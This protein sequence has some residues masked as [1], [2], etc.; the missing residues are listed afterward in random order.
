VPVL[1]IDTSSLVSVAVVDDDTVVARGVET[2]PRVH[3]ERLSMVIRDAM[4]DSGLKGTDLE[5]IAVGTGPAP[6]TGLRIGL[7]T[8]RVLSLAWGI[9]AWG[10]CS[11]DAIGAEHGGEVTVVTDARRREVYW[12]TYEAGERVSGP[13]VTTPTEVAASGERVGRGTLLYAEAFSAMGDTQWGE[14]GSDRESPEVPFLDPDPA[15][16]ARV[17]A[18]RIAGG[19]T[20]LPTTPLYL[21]RPDTHGIAPP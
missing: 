16:L 13:F 21:R 15:W 17:A 11:L 10:V 14:P 3:V 2:A 19:E 5:G 1:A 6:F 8:A 20:D 9:P 4:A 12:A 18:R 7:V